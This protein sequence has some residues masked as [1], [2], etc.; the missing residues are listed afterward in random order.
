MP[1][2]KNFLVASDLSPRADHALARGAQLAVEH[3]A[4]LT[5]L[6]VQEDL[7]LERWTTQGM[8]AAE[9]QLQHK[10]AAL[11]LP[12]DRPVA[13]RTAVGKPFVEIVRHAREEQAEAVIIGAHGAHVIKDL[14]VGATAEEVIRKG[15]RAV[16]VVKQAS[17]EAYRRVLVAVDFSAA[18]R[19]AV[20][21]ALVLAPHAEFHILHVSGV[22]FEEQLRLAGVS[23]REILDRQREQLADAEQHMKKF[24]HSINRQRQKIF[25]HL[26]LEGRARP[27][28][29]HTAG[30]LRA[31]LVAVGTTGHSGLPSLL[32]GSVSQHVLR[33]VTCDVF[34]VR[35]TDFRFEL[36]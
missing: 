20:E 29:A 18:S 26:V 28:I 10:L 22:V 31:D 21:Q 17:A 15:D 13:I 30:R 23:E 25:H 9:R 19:R 34:L 8:K 35:P 11:Q 6:Y 27:L 36:P 33:T 14:F 1:H 2:P 4:K 24:L 7:L 5:V 12:P 16:L 32:L 3:K